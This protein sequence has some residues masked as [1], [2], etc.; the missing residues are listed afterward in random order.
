M[1]YNPR[2]FFAQRVGGG[3]ARA[4]QEGGEEGRKEARD[5]RQCRN[6]AV[7]N[8]LRH[9]TD[10]MGEDYLQ[11]QQQIEEWSPWNWCSA[12]W[13]L[14]TALLVLERDH[15]W[16]GEEARYMARG[17]LAGWSHREQRVGGDGLISMWL[18]S[19]G[20]GVCDV[21]LAMLLEKLG[22]EVGTDVATG[23]VAWCDQTN[24]SI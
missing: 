4:G 21:F 1:L 9:G 10:E 2:S 23:A 3:A 13:V 17:S 16:E 19:S 18:G 22:S 7:T 8:W 20:R 12:V 14:V 24:L 11:E 6:R 15:Q 5:D